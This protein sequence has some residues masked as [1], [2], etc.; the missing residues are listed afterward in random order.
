MP[1]KKTTTPKTLKKLEAPVFSIAGKE[2]EKIALPAEI[3]GLSWNGD[4]VHQVVTALSANRRNNTAHA[5][6][7][8]EV[9]GGGKKP[10]KQK[11]TGR[12]R[13]GS[14]RSPIWVGGGVAHGPRNDKDFS[15]KINKKMARK[16]LLVAIS[17]KASDGEVLFV[18]AFTF[19]KPQT[20]EA[21]AF[22]QTLSKTYPKLLKPVNAAN[23]AL[24]EKNEGAFKSFRNIN[25]V[26]IADFRSLNALEILGKKFLIIEKPKEA[27]AFLEG[28]LAKKQ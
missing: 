16:A 27:I 1:I 14:T 9:R 4:L 3:F 23:I 11:G 25:N 6:T 28:K 26:S 18:D 5:K 21:L 15:Q 8:G 2:I 22:L 17:K 13:H 24:V 20:K 19:A 10:W 12:A 7:R